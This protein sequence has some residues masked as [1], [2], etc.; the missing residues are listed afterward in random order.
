MQGMPPELQ[1]IL[2]SMNFLV[3]FKGISHMHCQWLPGLRIVVNCD[4]NS[5][6]ALLEYIMQQFCLK[7][8]N[9]S[10]IYSWL[11]VDKLLNQLN[12]YILRGSYQKPNH[13][14]LTSNS[15]F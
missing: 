15:L 5:L 12:F 11:Y 6:L 10:P 14:S 4:E 8:P 9:V 2:R 3:K 13:L 1:K 7:K